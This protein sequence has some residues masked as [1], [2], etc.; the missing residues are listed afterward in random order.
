MYHPQIV[1]GVCVGMDE[2]EKEGGGGGDRG[3]GHEL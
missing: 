2:E 3:G 1:R